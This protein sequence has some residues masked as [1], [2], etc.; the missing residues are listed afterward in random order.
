[1]SAY[2]FLPAAFLRFWFLDAPKDIALYFFSLNNA[3][4]QQ[5]SLALLLRTFFKPIK[6]EYREGLIWFS[7]GMGMFVKFWLILVDLLLFLMLIFIEII[8]LVAFIVWPF[9][10]ISLIFL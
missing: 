10:T 9:V 6:N 7:I 4:L 5:F 1:M 3:F 8:L 2:L